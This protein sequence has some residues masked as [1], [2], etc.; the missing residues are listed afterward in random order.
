MPHY[1]GKQKKTFYNDLR[2]HIRIPTRKTV[3][4]YGLQNSSPDSFGG[5]QSSYMSNFRNEQYA[6]KNYQRIMAGRLSKPKQVQRD[7]AR[8]QQSVRKR[9]F[10]NSSASEQ[11]KQEQI[12]RSYDKRHAANKQSSPRLDDYFEN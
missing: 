9:T 11:L 10:C 8:S 5:T 7:V 6:M 3:D 2:R 4:R 12:Y 1:S